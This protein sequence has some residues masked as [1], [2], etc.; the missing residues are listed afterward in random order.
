MN[1]VTLRHALFPLSWLYGTVV[2]AR[3][4]SYERG[5][6]EQRSVGVPTVSV[7]NLTVGGSGKTPLVEYIARILLADGRRVAVVSRGYRRRTRGMR[8]VSDGREILLTSTESGDEPMQIAQ[9]VPGAV[10]VVDER[11]SRG[12]AI[13]VD[14][15]NADAVIL[16]DGFQHRAIRRDLDIVVHN[17]KERFGPLLPV[18]RFREGLPA[19]RRANAIVFSH[20][21]GTA[22]VMKLGDRLRSYTE[23]PMFCV[24]YRVQ[25]VRE[26]S[27][28][29]SV[30][31]ESLKGG[32]AVAFC[33]IGNPESFRR[34][35]MELGVEVVSFKTYSDHH[36]YGS[37][38]FSY[39]K[40]EQ[41]RTKADWVL[42]TQKDAVRIHGSAGSALKPAQGERRSERE[43]G[44]GCSIHYV[45]IG[46]QF[47]FG[48]EIFQRML[49]RTIESSAG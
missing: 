26:L 35:L 37:H 38:D 24:Q 23:A 34:T 3:N 6:F 5:M 36:S 11:R 32:T 46:V 48:D 17:A 4:W 25:D 43:R 18:G 41:E 14:R 8:V 44:E 7:G 10:V 16:D 1:L 45:A 39:L 22:E 9:N 20:C 15:Y 31:R 47:V 33:G 29:A 21:D 2:S 40:S 42:T 27:T 28:E 19:L 13:A 12:A 49:R 30:G